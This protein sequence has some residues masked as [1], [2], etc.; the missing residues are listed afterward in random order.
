MRLDERMCKE[1]R[2]ILFWM[3][4][5]S[6]HFVDYEPTNIR[7]EPY[8]PNMTPFVQPLDAGIIRTFKAKYRSEFCQR[9]L[10]R[11]EAG[12]ADLYD[13]SILEAMLMSKRAWRA[14]KHESIMNCWAHTKTLAK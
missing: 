9:A 12:E 14:V 4:N 7:V 5:F 11:E 6:A 1:G 3:D 13:I 2:K 8:E 10:D